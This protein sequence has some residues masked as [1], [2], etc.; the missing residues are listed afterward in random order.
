MNQSELE[1][2]VDQVTR[3]VLAGLHKE[4]G[5]I[6]AAQEGMKRILVVGQIQEPVP[7]TLTRD[8][9]LFDLEDYRENKNI[10]RYDQLLIT[11]LSITQL[12]DI[13]QAR[14]SD[15]VTCAVLNA[16]LNGIETLILDN[17]L[18]FHRFAG[19]GSTALYQMLEGYAQTLQ[20]FGVKP[21]GQKEKVRQELPPAKPPRFQA[22]VITAPRGSAKPSRARLITETEAAELLAEGG[23][24]HLPAG[25]LVTPLAK[26]LF[27]QSG[28]RVIRDC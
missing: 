11:H 18:S 3:Q 26:D 10:L 25:A 13:A 21:V 14:I 12:S 23:D 6:S 17:A 15:D 19:K 2:I 5:I 16:L 4:T 22:P 24:I 9:V 27:D 1:L 20:V 28:L 8:A 7:E